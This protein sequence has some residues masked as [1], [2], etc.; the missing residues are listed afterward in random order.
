VFPETF[1]VTVKAIPAVGPPIIVGTQSVSLAPSET[2]TLT[3]VWTTTG[4][5]VG[6]YTI[7]AAAA[8]VPGEAN[9]LNNALSD[10]QVKVTILGDINADNIV[11]IKD[12]TL[13]GINWMKIVPPADPNVDINDDGIINIKDATII[14][15]NWMKTYP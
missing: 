2:R 6:S 3:F 15:T 7:E 5:S 4:A 1:D 14:G 9:T 10:G 11:N 8:T 13:I 12:A